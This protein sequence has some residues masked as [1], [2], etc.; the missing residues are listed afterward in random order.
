MLFRSE[1]SVYN[2]FL[3]RIPLGVE[4]GLTRILFD[5]ASILH[6]HLFL[7]ANAKVDKAAKITQDFMRVGK[8]FADGFSKASK[9]SQANMHNYILEANEKQIPHN[10]NT[11]YGEYGFSGKE[12]ETITA[13]R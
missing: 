10:V 3:D 11:L 2:N 8:K 6:P 5:P 12:I 1:M 7:G 9:D 13:F 4:L